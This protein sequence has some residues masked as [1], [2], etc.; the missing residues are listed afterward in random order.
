MKKFKLF[1]LSFLMFSANSLRAESVDEALRKYINFF[2]INTIPTHQK[3]SNRAQIELGKHLFIAPIISGN[4]NINCL[5]CHDPMKG[6]SDALSLSQTHDGK[7]I[8][9]RNSQHLYNTGLKTRVHMFWDGRVSFNPTTKEF[10]TP[11]V[12]FN[13]PNPIRSDITEVMTSALSMQVIFPMVNDLEMKGRVGENEIANAKTNLEAFDLIVKRLIKHPKFKSQ[14]IAAYP[15]VELSKINIGHIGEALAE[16]IRE[17]FHSEGAPVHQYVKG[18]LKALSERQKLGFLTFIE[19]GKCNACHMGGEFG[20]NTFYASVGVPQFGAR[21]FSKDIGR[22]EIK[23]EEFKKYFFRV[24]S[25]INLKVTA[26]YFHNGAYTTIRDVINHYSNI[27]IFS[28][29]FDLSSDRRSSF[30]VEVEVEVITHPVDQREIFQSIQAPFLK[31]GLNF[32]E[33]E[34]DALED[35]LTNG[36]MDPKFDLPSNF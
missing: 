18:D 4:R 20:N 25:L 5:T 1:I 13:G 14:I 22:G 2:G 8:L 34:K 31:K 17:E 19:K 36:L 12:S 35:F 15:D 9:K 29:S 3:I 24:P 30:P 26:P 6:T 7:G 16:F 28:S 10:Q 11:E 33:I 23:G 27:E 21:P 32:T